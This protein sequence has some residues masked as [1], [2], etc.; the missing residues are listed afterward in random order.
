VTSPVLETRKKQRLS[1]AN[2]DKITKSV[3][4]FTEKLKKV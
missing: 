4:N 1:G 2:P 3:I